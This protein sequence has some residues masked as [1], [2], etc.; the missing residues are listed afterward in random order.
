MG[1]EVVAFGVIEHDVFGEVGPV[2][3][4]EVQLIE[5]SLLVWGSILFSK[6]L[7]IIIEK[8]RTKDKERRPI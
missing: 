1:E 5:D 4:V 8:E 2:V 3:F 6:H 7:L